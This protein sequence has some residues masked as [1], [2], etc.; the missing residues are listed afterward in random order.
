VQDADKE[1]AAK[2]WNYD[3]LN[4]LGTKRKNQADY[5]GFTGN[6][7]DL[8]DTGAFRNSVKIVK[9]RYTV[10]V[11]Y[12]VGYA[13][14]IEDRANFLLEPTNNFESRV[15]HHVDNINVSL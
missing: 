2:K 6:P 1:I 11:E 15:Q 9:G 13:K 3:S 14:I 5:P 10:S 12:G 8:I 7:R 4:P